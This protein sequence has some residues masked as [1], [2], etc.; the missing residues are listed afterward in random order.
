VFGVGR[1]EKQP[2]G[3]E[4]QGSDHGPGEPTGPART[5]G[6]SSKK[7]ITI[8]AVAAAVALAGGGYALSQSGGPSQAGHAQLS[9]QAAGPIRIE[10]ISPASGAVHVDGAQ[11]ITV[12]FS[13]QLAADSPDP[14][15]QPAIA[16]SWSTQGNQLVFMPSV[17]L[18]P[19]THVTVDVPSGPA[20]VRG[21]GGGLL[22]STVSDTF[23]T[24]GYS[25][26]RLAEVLGQLGYLPLTWAQD[27]SGGMK[28]E[29]YTGPMSQ[30]A[31]A[32]DPPAGTFTWEPGYPYVLRS[33]W[34]ADQPNVIVRG[35][36]M[37]FQSEHHMT[38]DGVVNFA[39]WRALFKAAASN[40][41]NANGYS[42]AIASKG[43][44]ETLTIWHDGRQVMQSLANTGIPVSPTVDGSFPVY[45]RLPFQ[46][47][48]GV[49]PDG[50]SYADPV[51]FVS[52]FNGGDAVHY[53]PRGSY[54]FQQ[55]LGCVELPYDSA[56][57]AYPY[58]TYGSI[59]TVMG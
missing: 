47:M 18:P 23:S 25:Q 55:S 2:A 21:S 6:G 43:A 1:P 20:G 31:L 35:A 22:T 12:T 40:Q 30:A 36:V 44:P 42:Y 11:P 27:V 28:E 24:S 37:A 50:S 5:K 17:S 19:S 13:A 51:S 3:D 39:L 9:Q 54:G 58:L 48:R 45:L 49:N 34:S 59:V 8:G 10:S 16:G 46:I 41:Q 15:L 7:V 38:I 29:D 4:P 33:L 56:E 53:F 32:F 57:Q 14:T 26:L 52:Y